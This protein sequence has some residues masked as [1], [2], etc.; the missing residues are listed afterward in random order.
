MAGM[1]KISV[2]NEQGIKVRKCCAS[3]QH[4]CIKTDGV[5]HTKQ[6]IRNLIENDNLDDFLL[7][8]E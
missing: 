1:R 2:R 8:N 4:K 3:C 5:E 7:Y 6:I